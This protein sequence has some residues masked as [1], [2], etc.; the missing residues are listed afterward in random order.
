MLMDVIEGTFIVAPYQRTGFLAFPTL[1]GSIRKSPEVS[2]I[3]RGFLFF[4][5]T[6]PSRFA[7]SSIVIEGAIVLFWIFRFIYFLFRKSPGLHLFTAQAWVPPFGYGLTMT[8][9]SR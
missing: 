9:L 4:R 6:R 7:A 1:S 8:S 5:A 2:C 3:F